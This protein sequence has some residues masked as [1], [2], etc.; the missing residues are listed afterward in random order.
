M[1]PLPAP[2]RRRIRQR[3]G[4]RCRSIL[5]WLSAMSSPTDSVGRS[6]SRHRWRHG[7]APRIQPPILSIWRHRA[8]QPCTIRGEAR[9]PRRCG[10]A[11][12]LTPAP[13]FLASACRALVELITNRPSAIKFRP[14]NRYHSWHS[15][16]HQHRCGGLSRAIARW[17]CRIGV[18]RK[19]MARRGTAAPKW[20]FNSAGHL[21]GSA[22][23]GAV[24]HCITI[25][26][27]PPR[28][29]LRPNPHQRR[30]TTN[31]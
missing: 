30:L 24:R 5:S 15:R 8:E 18:S 1:R 2:A 28:R 27:A 14:R 31:A 4:A 10:K 9:R 29:P 6:R 22:P 23:E 20:G 26:A 16:R 13:Q 21:I 19:R 25:R 3:G 11:P 12:Q 17:R 7:F